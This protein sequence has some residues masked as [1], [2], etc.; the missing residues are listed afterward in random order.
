MD[1][2]KDGWVEGCMDGWMDVENVNERDG[3]EKKMVQRGLILQISCLLYFGF[4]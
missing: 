4:R 1:G 3:G 2:W